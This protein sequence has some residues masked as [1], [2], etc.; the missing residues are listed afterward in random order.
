MDKAD[1]KFLTCKPWL[2]ALALLAI[3]VIAYQPVWHAGFIWDDDTYVTTNKS[4]QSISGLRQIWL[5]PNA[6]A[7]YYPLTFTVFWIEYH[8][9]GLQPLG[10]HLLN[11]LLQAANAVLF[12]RLLLALK[13]PGAWWAAAVF[14]V[15][16]VHVMSVAWITELKNV[17]SAFFYLLALL[18]YLRFAGLD[19]HRSIRPVS[20]ERFYWLTLGLYLCALLSKTSTCI[21]PVALLLIQWWKHGRIGRKDLVEALPM[22]VIGISFGVFTLWLEKYAKGG[23]GE[24]FRLSFFQRL[25]VFGRSFWFSLGKLVWPVGL[26]FIYPRWNVNATNAGQ[27]LFPLSVAALMAALWRTQR[28]FGRGPFA[29]MIYFAL[30]FPALILV[31][32]L[33]MMRYSFVSDHWQYLGS[34]GV[35]PVC[36]GGVVI[37]LDR[38]KPGLYKIT[39]LVGVVVL[40]GLGWL[41]WRQ[42][43]IYRDVETLWRDTLAKNPDAWMARNNLGAALKQAG[44]NQDAVREFEQALRLNPD[45]GYAQINLGTALLEVRKIQEAIP[46]FERAVQVMPNSAMAHNGLGVALL[47]AGRNE[48]ATAQFEQTLKLD[49]NYADAHHNLGIILLQA[50]KAQD[51]IVELEQAVRLKPDSANMQ[52]KLA[53]ALK[54]TGRTEDAIRHYEEALRISPTN[55]NNRINF[56]NALLQVGRIDDAIQQY[57]QALRV[58][59]DSAVGQFNLGNALL[60]A[61]R[62]NDAIGHYQRAVQLKPD[63]AE[64]KE[65]LARLTGQLVTD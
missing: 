31:Q 8:L 9:W 35:I 28:W 24:E 63:F 37:V 51:A 39:A 11:V 21:L 26:T 49:P 55:A 54:Q 42:G 1:N 61:G 40:A 52:F 64:A 32:A 44:R 12:W 16:P 34:M 38:W 23:L 62:R 7:Q 29:G 53:L 57:E 58:A 5:N 20:L 13:V 45:D 33:F 43:H 14:A 27:Y 59:P 36:V 25:L 47:N 10:F 6:T 48:E 50:A 65:K 56:G 2:L 41:T 46:H 19:N 17:L 22:I 3:T 18:S 4:L 60:Q 15:H 30:A